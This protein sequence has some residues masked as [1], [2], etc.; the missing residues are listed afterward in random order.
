MPRKGGGMT[1]K[2]VL[3]L[4]TAL[5][6]AAGMAGPATAGKKK[7]PKPYT[8]EDGLIVAPH[9]MLYSSTGEVNS[10]TANEFENRCAIPASNGLDAYVY[11][12]PKEYQSIEAQIAAHSGATVA[13]D[14][15][16]FF[17]DKD[18]QMLPVPI[19]AQGAV[20]NADAEGPMPK[21]TTYVL[22]ANFAGEPGT[23]FYEL[24]P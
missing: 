24:K 12:V 21:G 11:E 22:I 16:I 5:V 18:C 19:A 1:L 7:A 10:V 4:T 8:S 2:R 6:L 13:W 9:T 23:V 3:A 20:T 14:L 15:Y 17:Y